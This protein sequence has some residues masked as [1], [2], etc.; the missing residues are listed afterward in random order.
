MLMSLAK[1]RRNHLK[2]TSGG[3]PSHP[4]WIP[5]HLTKLAKHQ[6]CAHKKMPW[7]KIPP[8]PSIPTHV[9]DGWVFLSCCH[10]RGK[11]IPP[12]FLWH[13]PKNALFVGQ[14]SQN[15]HRFAILITP[16]HGNLEN[17]PGPIFGTEKYS[18]HLRP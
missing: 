18:I 5:T 14:I 7:N 11:Y 1:S 6:N 13:Q 3:S 15:D 16:E 8:S 12:N 2:Q 9:N 4:R 17:F 10:L